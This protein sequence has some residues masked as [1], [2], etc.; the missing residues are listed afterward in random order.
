MGSSKDLTMQIG[1][2][3]GLQVTATMT[4]TGKQVFVIVS[5][6]QLFFHQI[7]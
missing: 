1:G 5:S 2:E 4:A 7:V 3:N 6:F